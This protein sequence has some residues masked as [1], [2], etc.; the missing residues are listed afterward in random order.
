MAD[1]YKSAMVVDL[2]KGVFGSFVATRESVTEKGYVVVEY[3]A[4]MKRMFGF[5]K[6]VRMKNSVHK[7][8]ILYM[9]YPASDEAGTEESVVYIT[10]GQNGLLAQKLNQDYVQRIKKKD[11]EIQRLKVEVATA[12]KE[13][14]DAVSGLGTGIASAKDALNSGRR[15]EVGYTPFGE[16]RNTPW[17]SPPVDDEMDY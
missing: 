13:A 9:K 12:K 6:K 1:A 16:R 17:S 11:E 2:D 14:K 3:V 8:D 10:R 5:P 7:D 15:T 4:L